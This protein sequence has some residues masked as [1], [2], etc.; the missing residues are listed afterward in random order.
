MR[1]LILV[2][3]TVA[4]VALPTSIA[5]VTAAL[6]RMRAAY[7]LIVIEGAGSPAELVAG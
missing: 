1:R 2:V 7:E 5:V 6:D 3:A 4:A